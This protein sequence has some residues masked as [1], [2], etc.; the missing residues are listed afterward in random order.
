[1]SSGNFDEPGPTSTPP[2]PAET[3]TVMPA[4]YY[5]TPP[6][7]AQRIVPRGV[8]LGCGIASIVAVLLIFAVGAFL[9][10]G[11]MA[12]FLDF[13]LGQTLGE[14][15]GCYASDVSDAQKQAF[16][17]ELE[18]L[19]KRVRAETLPV[20][21]LSPVLTELQTAI[22]DRSVRAEEVE[23]LRGRIREAAA[24]ETPSPDEGGAPAKAATPV[25]S[26]H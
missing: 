1:M 22:K 24:P 13:A 18:E 15:R 3:Q 26:K 2:A 17:G 11:G 25:A 7:E 9:A 23:R 8:V 10:R 20:A 5:S 4:E 16:E 14:V 21:R 12:T 6:S 19:R